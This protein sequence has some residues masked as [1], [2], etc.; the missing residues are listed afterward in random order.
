MLKDILSR[1]AAFLAPKPVPELGRNEPCHCGSG[2]KY[3]RCCLAKDA[4]RLRAER[5]AGAAAGGGAIGGGGA[6]GKRGLPRANEQGPS[7]GKQGR[8]DA[9]RRPR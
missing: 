5:D 4:E 8:F 9:G 3:K 1:L 7:R 6:S 2:R